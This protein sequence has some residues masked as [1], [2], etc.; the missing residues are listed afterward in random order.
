MHTMV[1]DIGE[2]KL[3]THPG[4]NLFFLKMIEEG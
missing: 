3:K 4:V 2:A 1:I